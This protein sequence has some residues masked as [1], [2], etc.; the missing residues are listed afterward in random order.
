MWSARLRGT[1]QGG[2]NERA[3]TSAH[4]LQNPPANNNVHELRA[5][6]HRP[7]S[8]DGKVVLAPESPASGPSRAHQR[9]QGLED[10]DV[11]RRRHPRAYHCALAVQLEQHHGVP[12]LAEGG[13]D[14]AQKPSSAQ[15]RDGQAAVFDN[16]RKNASTP[17]GRRAGAG[18]PA[19]AAPHTQNAVQGTARTW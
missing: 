8:H 17:N 12:E 4:D 19:P 11:D 10:P 6:Q 5:G 14:V 18:N 1:R 3:R 9:R 16:K 7:G 2:A 13:R 15:R